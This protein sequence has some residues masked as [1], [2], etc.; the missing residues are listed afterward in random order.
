M[1]FFSSQIQRA[2]NLSLSRQLPFVFLSGVVQGHTLFLLALFL[3]Y[4]LMPDPQSF[5]S[6]P[7]ACMHTAPLENHCLGGSR[8]CPADTWHH[9]SSRSAHVS[10][11]NGI[12][13]CSHRE[14]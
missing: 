1:S 14:S 7:Y 6:L 3:L 11:D 4:T 9:C 2:V 8:Q 12:Y 10:L 5:I 13:F